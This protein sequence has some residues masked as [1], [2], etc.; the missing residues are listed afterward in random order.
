M[1]DCLLTMDSGSRTQINTDDIKNGRATKIGN[2][3]LILILVSLPLLGLFI[4]GIYSVVLVLK[5][6]D[7][8]EAREKSE[9]QPDQQVNRN[10]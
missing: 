10:S 3:T 6:D 4:M 9:R 1:I 8:Y 5:I 7:E 2:D